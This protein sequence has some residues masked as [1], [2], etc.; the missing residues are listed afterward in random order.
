MGNMASTKTLRGYGLRDKNAL[1]HY[2]PF[3]LDIPL[4][5]KSRRQA[6]KFNSGLGCEVVK[7]KVKIEVVEA[8]ER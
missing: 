8:H 6:V 7:V 1:N 3:K 4:L 5:F 2:V